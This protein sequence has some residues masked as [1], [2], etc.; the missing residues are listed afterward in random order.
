[1]LLMESTIEPLEKITSMSNMGMALRKELQVAIWGL[2]TG[3]PTF[4]FAQNSFGRPDEAVAEE[5]LAN[6][7]R[8][9]NSFVHD[10]FQAQFRSSL[11]CPKC[12]R[13]SNTF[14]PFLCASVPVPQTRRRP[15]YVTVLYLSQQP[16]QDCNSVY[17]GSTRRKFMDRMKE[18]RRAFIRNMPEKSN[19]AKHLIECG[20]WSDFEIVPCHFASTL[21]LPL[22]P[23]PTLSL[24]SLTL[25]SPTS[26]PLDLSRHKG[27]KT[28]PDDFRPIS[29][30]SIFCS[31]RTYYLQICNAF[32]RRKFCDYSKPAWLPER[33][34]L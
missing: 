10:L 24:P 7:K 2:S 1:M 22:L 19:F 25:S 8:C 9:N 23:F 21:L 12:H 31:F 5:T 16:R 18:H 34:L 30:R 32:P 17:V 29:L 27:H 13:Q 11:T 28:K 3:P 4:S 33:P 6:H 20:H 14:D 15:L 26:P